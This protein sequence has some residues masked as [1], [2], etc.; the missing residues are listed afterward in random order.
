[1]IADTKRCTIF[2]ILI[3]LISVCK[4]TKKLYFSVVLKI[5]TFYSDLHFWNSKIDFMKKKKIRLFKEPEG[6]FLCYFIK[7]KVF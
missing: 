5:T 3:K 7:E 1:M 2:F 6:A 4:N